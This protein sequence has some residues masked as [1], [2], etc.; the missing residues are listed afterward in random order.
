MKREMQIVKNAR[1]GFAYEQLVLE[2][3]LTVLVAPMPG[4]KGIHAVYGTNFGS[5]DLC[6]EQ[7]GKTVA[8]PAGT[9]HFMEHKMFEKE[10]GD[11]FALYAKTGASAN[12]FTGFER[13]CYVFSATQNIDESMDILLSLVTTPYFT[14]E[15]VKKEQGI[16][17][18][19]IKMYDDSTDWRMMFALLKCIYHSC[20]VKEDIAG[21]VESIA[22]I[23]PELLYACAGAF[24]TPGNMVLSV[25][26]NI[27]AD[28]VLAAVERAGLQPAAPVAKKLPA[29]EPLEIVKPFDS[30]E[31]AIAQ[32]V[33]GVGFKEKAWPEAERLKG[34]IICD[35]LC[36]LVCGPITP[37]FSRLYDEGLINGEFAGECGSGVGYCCMM[38][39]GETADPVRLREEL[40]ARIAQLKQTGI[41]QEDFELARN[42]AY[43]EAVSDL[44]QMETVAT[45]MAGCAMRGAG[46]FDQ[47]EILAALTKDEVQSALAGMF[48][49]EKEATVIIRPMQDE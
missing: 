47:M 25:A 42:L 22:Q 37:F 27:T 38:F 18:Q 35:L 9:A 32:P 24:Y 11:A 4:Y 30:F 28:R 34:E 43:G 31:M 20:P 5:V 6:F 48:D 15:T 29:F 49:P 36:D 39:S 8:L 23:T 1:T 45:A 7:A 21:T 13:T 3:G 12:A 33:L 16:I 46:L 40:L 44:E 17:G 14:E 2:N 26:G 41:S 10:E 19:E